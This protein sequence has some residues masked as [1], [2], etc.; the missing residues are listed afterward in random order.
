ALASVLA[1]AVAVSSAV[2]AVASRSFDT[3]NYGQTALTI[4]DTDGDGHFQ[5]PA[6]LRKIPG[7]LQFTED[8]R[9]TVSGTTTIQVTQGVFYAQGAQLVTRPGAPLQ[10]LVILANGGDFG[11]R[12][13]LDLTATGDVII[14]AKN[15]LFLY[16]TTHVTTPGTIALTSKNDG[17]GVA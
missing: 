11:G 6:R 2:A 12:G 3:N 10:K 14:T 5:W 4:Y 7:Q 17:V 16:G 13:L 1:I 9:I 8:E 15:E